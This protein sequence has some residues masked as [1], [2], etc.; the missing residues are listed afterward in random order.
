MIC[1]DWEERQKEIWVTH[2][3]LALVLQGMIGFGWFFLLLLGSFCSCFFNN[4]ICKSS[5]FSSEIS[6][7]F[8]QLHL[9]VMLL[10]PK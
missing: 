8:V 1:S 9:F 3:P 10:F 5:S 4:P 7:F 6:S 2:G